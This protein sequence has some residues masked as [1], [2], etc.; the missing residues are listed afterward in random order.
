M[1][2]GPGNQQQ[3]QWNDMHWEPSTIRYFRHMPRIIPIKLV[4]CLM[5]FPF[6]LQFWCVFHRKFNHPWATIRI[7]WSLFSF[8][9]TFWFLYISIKFLFSLFDQ[10]LKQIPSVRSIYSLNQFFWFAIKITQL[11]YLRYES[12][13]MRYI[14]FPMVEY[15]HIA[16][17]RVEKLVITNLF[18]RQNIMMLYTKILKEKIAFGL[19]PIKI[20]GGTKGIKTRPLKISVLEFSVK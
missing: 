5:K 15:C 7:S 9:C 2:V 14:Y 19:R 13:N 10:Q 18:Y 20:S 3:E 11:N 16:I 17:K 4:K 6:L 1:V 12:R 8:V